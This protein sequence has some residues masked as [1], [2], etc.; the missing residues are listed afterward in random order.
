MR[1]FYSFFMIIT[2]YIQKKTLGTVIRK[3]IKRKEK[4]E[5]NADE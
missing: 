2:Y 3:K 5:G 4:G 1:E